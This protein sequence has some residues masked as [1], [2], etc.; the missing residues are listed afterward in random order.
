MFLFLAEPFMA[1]LHSYIGKQPETIK[2][3]E[4]EK[5]DEQGSKISE[6]NDD[7]RVQKDRK[8]K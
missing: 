6:L 1:K 4:Q 2:R 7:S 8:K 5:R 3:C